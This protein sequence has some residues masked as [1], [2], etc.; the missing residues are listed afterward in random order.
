[1][2]MRI[3]WAALVAGILSGVVIT[4]VQAVKVTP[5]IYEAETYEGAGH[6]HG[7]E[8][9]T[10]S[11]GAHDHG[12]HDHGEAWAPHDGFE[13][14]F[15]TG[16]ANVLTS[17]GFAFLLVAGFTLSK[18]E[19]DWQRG[20]LWG[21]GGFAAF[22][23]IPGVIL[24]PEVP[25]AAAAAV[26]TRQLYWFGIAGVSA[27]GLML[28]FLGKQM[29]LRMLGAAL[30]VGPVFLVSPHGE[31]HGTVPP[32]LAAHFVAASLGTAAIFWAC[33]GG[34]AGHFYQRFMGKAA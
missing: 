19:M 5:L 14:I 9:A 6:S 20:L 30:A 24:P 1:M 12:A 15:F 32:E 3:L 2:I 8:A 28:C 22:A 26:E 25:G 18:R 10:T 31:G 4:G 17:V 34:L 33:L 11:E 16:L 7:E 13:R 23:L 27:V 21:L 29:A